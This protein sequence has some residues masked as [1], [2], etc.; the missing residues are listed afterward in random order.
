MVSK[1]WPWIGGQVRR[2]VTPLLIA[3]TLLGLGVWS[4][5]EGE[6]HAA[7]DAAA[8]MPAIADTTLASDDGLILPPPDDAMVAASTA[9]TAR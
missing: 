2:L 4:F 1:R 9:A 7:R 3:M 5:A 6:R 8:G